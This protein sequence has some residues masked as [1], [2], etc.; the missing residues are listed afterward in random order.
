[1]PMAP[2]LFFFLA[3]GFLIFRPFGLFGPTSPATADTEDPESQPEQ[4][5]NC[6]EYI[7][8]LLKEQ[9]RMDASHIQV[10]DD[11][12]RAIANI[13]SADE[14]INAIAFEAATNELCFIGDTTP[15]DQ[16]GF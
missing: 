4:I 10:I 11:V 8:E 15:P 3:I 6:R 14:Q 13:P 1:M 16:R 12:E 5:T 2:N 9:G 7:V